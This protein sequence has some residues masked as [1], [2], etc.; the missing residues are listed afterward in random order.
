LTLLNFEKL[1]EVEYDACGIGINGVLSQEKRPMSFFSEKLS[2]V[3]LKWFINDKQFYVI[4]E[5]F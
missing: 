3:R 1:F 4:F 2:D 5:T